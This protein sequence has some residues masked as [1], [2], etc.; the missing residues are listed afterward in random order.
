[1]LCSRDQCNRTSRPPLRNRATVRTWLREEFAGRLGEPSVGRL[2]RR[3]VL[4]P[5]RP[6]RRATEQDPGAGGEMAARGIP[7]DSAT[8]QGRYC[9]VFCPRGRERCTL[10]LPH[11]PHLDYRGR[12]PGG[13]ARRHPV[14]A[15]DAVGDQ[16]PTRG[17]LHDPR[18]I[19]RVG[20]FL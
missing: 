2:M 11:G 9:H 12:L 16:S 20:D 8:T 14:F 15:T 19:G 18:R 7:S 1:M 10:N 5:L 13:S 3:L 4:S 6:L 17:P